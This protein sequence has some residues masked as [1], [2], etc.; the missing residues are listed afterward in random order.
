MGQDGAYHKKPVTLLAVRLTAPFEVALSGDRGRLN[1]KPGD[2]LVEFA[3][4]DW[5]IV[6]D[7]V[8]ATTYDVLT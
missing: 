6:N 2:W 7:A 4:D 8:F 1:G 5:G 3:S